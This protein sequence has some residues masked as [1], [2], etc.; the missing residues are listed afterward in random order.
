LSCGG[1][2][3]EVAGPSFAVNLRVEVSIEAELIS[4]STVFEVF[5]D[6]QY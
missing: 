4:I 3:A 1:G 2:E 6:A 5:V